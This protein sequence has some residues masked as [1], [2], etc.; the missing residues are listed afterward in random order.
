MV[1][2]KSR[3]YCI[4]FFWWKDGNSENLEIYRHCQV[5][6]RIICSLFFLAA[7]LTYN[8]DQAPDNVK[9]IAVKVKE[10]FYADNCVTNVQSTEELEYFC[11]EAWKLLVSARFDQCGWFYKQCMEFGLGLNEKDHLS[12]GNENEILLLSLMLDTRRDTLSCDFWN[13]KLENTITKVTILSLMH[14]IFNPI[15]SFTFP[16][17][18]ITKL[19]LQKCWKI[20]ASWDSKLPNKIDQEFVKWTNK[21]DDFRNLEKIFANLHEEYL[22]YQ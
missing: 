17:I 2:G 3:V 11:N 5:V 9:H 10:T 22:I 6:F 14:K 13:F 7:I 16:V 8:L 21:I 19:F 15:I 1:A 4:C 18:L 20:K 12:D